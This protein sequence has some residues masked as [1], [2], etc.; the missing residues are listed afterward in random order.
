MPAAPA[1]PDVSEAGGS[2]VAAAV[3]GFR[4]PLEG[5]GVLRRNRSLW[6]LAAAPVGLSLVSVAVALGLVIEYAAPIHGFVSGWI[7]MLEAASWYEWL[8]VGPARIVLALLGTL[9]FLAAAGLSLVLGFLVAKLLSS[10]ILDT[11]SERVERI[12]S[13]QPVEAGT[14]LRGVLR[15]AGA[16]MWN[17]LRRLLFFVGVW[18]AIFALAAVVPGAQLLAAPAMI[19]F[20]ILFLPLDYAGYALDRRRVPFRS[21]RV[22]VVGNLP[23]MLGFGSSAFVTVLVPGLNFLLIPIL[24]AAGTLLALRHPPASEAERVA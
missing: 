21:R 5:F 19:G 1:T 20:T 14:G 9:L 10:P 22:W 18:A 7:P 13:G 17:E 23:R 16:S 4:L 11:L 3:S 8:W 6:A 15:D 24:V 2:S 12:V